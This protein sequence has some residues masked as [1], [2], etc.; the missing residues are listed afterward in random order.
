MEEQYKKRINVAVR[1]LALLHGQL[2]HPTSDW[3]AKFDKESNRL[4]KFVNDNFRDKTR[5]TLPKT[6]ERNRRNQPLPANVIGRH[7]GT[8]GRNDYTAQ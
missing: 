5:R 1:L 2:S 7:F 8:L 4:Y 3:L 6:N